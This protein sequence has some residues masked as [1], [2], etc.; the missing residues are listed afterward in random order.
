MAST[1]DVFEGEH[2]AFLVTKADLLARPRSNM[3][4]VVNEIF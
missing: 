1:L 4:L 3:R 2:T